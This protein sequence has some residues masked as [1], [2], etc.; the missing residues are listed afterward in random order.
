[1]L[2][3]EWQLGNQ[4]SQSLDQA[5]PADFRLW[6]AMLSP[7]VEEQAEFCRGLPPVPTA[8]DL[9]EYYQLPAERAP[10]MQVEDIDSMNHSQQLLL[11]RGLTEWRLQS[12][13]RPPPQ[14]VRHDANKLSADLWDNL[15][16]HCR[17]HLTPDEPK[18]AVITPDPALLLDVLDALAV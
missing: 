9:R 15:S 7:A 10:A 13:L 5:R 8:V 2:I 16:L 18:V 4:L 1:M 11:E 17:R 14:V 12:L 6:L 3:N